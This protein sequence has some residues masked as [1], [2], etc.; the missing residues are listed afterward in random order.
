M[1]CLGLAF[2]KSHFPAHTRLLQESINQF[3]TF[4]ILILYGNL[5]GFLNR[6]V[7]NNGY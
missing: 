6:I 7:I 4:D 5:F 3:V 2:F 1:L